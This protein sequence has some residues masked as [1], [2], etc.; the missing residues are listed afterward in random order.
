MVHRSRSRRR[1]ARWLGLLARTRGVVAVVALV[2][3]I[4]RADFFVIVVF[5]FGLSFLH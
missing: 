2:V 3:L 5:A 1:G 4:D